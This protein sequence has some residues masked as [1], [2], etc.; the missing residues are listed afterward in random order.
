MKSIVL[1]MVFVM[2][3]SVA[4]GDAIAVSSAGAINLTFNTSTRFEGM[5]S[6][7]VAAP[8][9]GDTNHWAN[10]AQLAFRLPVRGHVVLTVFDARGERVRTLMDR[11]MGE[12]EH[13]VTWD[14]SDDQGRR[15]GSGV[16]YYTLQVGDQVITRKLVMLK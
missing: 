10:P 11:A 13:G 15:L 7:G 5:G 4:A 12:G 14:G 3:L 1:M 6:A 8:W 2:V 16:Y 9:G